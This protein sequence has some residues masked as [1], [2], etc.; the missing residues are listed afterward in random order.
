MSATASCCFSSGGCCCTA[1][2]RACQVLKA[3]ADEKDYPGILQISSL[4]HSL[5][6]QWGRIYFLGIGVGTHTQRQVSE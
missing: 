6:F 4:T 1:L 2:E 5:S 3:Q